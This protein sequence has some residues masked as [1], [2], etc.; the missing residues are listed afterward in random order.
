MATPP[1]PR[2]ESARPLGRTPQPKI[3]F[4][5]LDLLVVVLVLTLI[6]LAAVYQFPAYERGE[7][8]PPPAQESQPAP[9]SAPS[10]R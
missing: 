5:L 3:G 4:S 2:V 9:P 8:S 6:L 10:P 1:L 7:T